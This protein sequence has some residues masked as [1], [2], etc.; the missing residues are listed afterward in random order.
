MV[1]TPMS[2][3]V[4]MHPLSVRL[5]YSWRTMMGPLTAVPPADL[6]QLRVA[7]YYYSDVLEL[8]R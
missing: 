2:C 4:H 7:V 6:L 3:C 5:I 1:R 8:V